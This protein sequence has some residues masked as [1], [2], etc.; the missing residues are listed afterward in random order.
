MLSNIAAQALQRPGFQDF[1]RAQD[2]FNARKK[3]REQAALLNQLGIEKA[4]RELNAPQL[5]FQGSSWDAQ[6]ANEAYKFNLRKGMDEA[7][8]R[9]SAID[10]VQGGKVD[11]SMVTDPYTGQ[12]YPV[13]KPRASIFGGAQ[14]STQSRT[15]GGYVQPDIQGSDL[16]PLTV[17]QIA[18]VLSNG[19]QMPSEVNNAP[20]QEKTDFERVMGGVDPRA[21]RSPKVQQDMAQAAYKARLD[22]EAEL[23]GEER[24]SNELQKQNLNAYNSFSIG[25]KNVKERMSE[26]FTN[27]VSGALPALTPAQQGAEGSVSVMAPILKQLFRTAGEGTFT[28]KD[29]EL[30]MGMLPTR[31]DWPSVRKQKLKTIDDIVRAKLGIGGAIGAPENTAPSMGR[32]ITLQEFLAE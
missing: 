6:V 27:P 9:Q 11:Y 23:R 17:E 30:L 10:M 7:S 29:Q 4:Q 21:L 3:E 32:T 22:E 24:K 20:G 1:M 28:D 25:V 8:A 31:D 15:G 19:Q 5:P 14:R 2:E 26:T 13:A 12:S 16:Q 18:T